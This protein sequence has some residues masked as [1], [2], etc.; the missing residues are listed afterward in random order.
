MKSLSKYVLVTSLGLA[1]GCSSATEPGPAGATSPDDA[2]E[3]AKLALTTD[4]L[5]DTDLGGMRFTVTQVDCATGDPIVPGYT[6]TADVDLADMYIPGG[7]GTFEDAPYDA[8]SQHLFAD[9][10]FD[11]APGC[12]DVLVEPIQENGDPSQDCWSAHQDN[13]EVFAGSTTETL[14]ILQCRGE[15]NGGLDIIGT[16]NHPPQIDELEFQPSKF[17]CEQETRVCIDISDP[18]SDPME[19]DWSAGLSG[20]QIVSTSQQTTDEGVTTACATISAATPGTYQIKATV[21]DMGYDANGNLV[22]IEDLLI[23]QGDPHPS[24]AAI[25]FPIHVLS[26]EDCIETCEC[27]EGFQ[28]SDDGESCIR[29]ESVEPTYNGT[30]HTVCEGDYN[31]NYSA[32]GAMYPDGTPETNAFFGMTYDDPSSRLNTVGVWAC[33]QNGGVGTQPTNEWIGFTKC[34]DVPADGDYLVGMGADNQIRFSVDGSLIFSKTG[35][36]MENFRRWWMTPISL[37]AGT[38]VIEL[39]GR[40]NGSD[41]SFGAEIYGPFP[42][43]S[44]NSDAAMMAADVENNII[45]STGDLIGQE[46]QTG[47]NSGW[48]CPD[49]YAVSMCG[50][51]PECTRIREI[52]CLEEA[53]PADPA[54][55]V[56]P[57]GQ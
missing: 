21:F 11:L 51:K 6:E 1:V 25:K 9:Q 46:F 54:E 17:T 22:R 26:E 18:D 44:L 23:A 33:G 31:G 32:L 43:G 29:V 5:A 53:E 39:E 19:V 8:D 37:T 16:A 2:A 45:F 36:A 13:I 52:P 47:Q 3:T 41:A 50:D 14:L 15:D 40:N 10:Y 28:I 27:P 4:V 57:G 56:R 48:S 38:H 35:S 24:R 7:N 20:A 12:Y 42:A 55:P 30:T 34:I 49:G